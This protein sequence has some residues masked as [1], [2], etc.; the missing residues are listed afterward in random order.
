MSRPGGEERRL[1]ERRVA[2][3]RSESRDAD[4]ALEI[5]EILASDPELDAREIEV[6]VEDGT[7]TLRGIVDGSEAGLLAEELV[8]SLAG[9]R[10]V[11]N[12]LRVGREE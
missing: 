2:Q 3:R 6:Q 11:R 12:A 1:S 10:E 8:E 4:L 5:R 9:V 7:V